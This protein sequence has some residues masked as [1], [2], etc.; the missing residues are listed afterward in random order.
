MTINPLNPIQLEHGELLLQTLRS[1]DQFNTTIYGENDRYRGIKG[2][3]RI[4]FMN[5]DDMRERGIQAE[6]PLTITSYYKGTTRTAELFLAI[7]YGTPPGCVA[8]YYPEAN[9]LVPIDSFAKESGTPTSKS[10]VV[11]VEVY[12]CRTES[13]K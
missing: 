8:A 5:P 2:E 7:P 12:R 1:H 9:V 11:R 10:V 4:L 3:R 6:E 13:S